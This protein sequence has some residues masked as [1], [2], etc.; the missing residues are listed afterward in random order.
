ML[1][2]EEV[3]KQD[4]LAV[5]APGIWFEFCDAYR[6]NIKQF[7]C[8]LHMNSHYFN[9]KKY[10]CYFTSDNKNQHEINIVACKKYAS[11]IASS[12]LGQQHPYRDY[13]RNL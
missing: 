3:T 6:E 5:V 8:G 9:E 11:I 2:W 7:Y 4:S 10:I 13:P 1:H 12:Y